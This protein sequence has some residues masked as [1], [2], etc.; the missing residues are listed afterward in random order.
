MP[1]S[2]RAR[3]TT[4]APR[5][6]PS[7]PGL[8]TRTRIWRCWVMGLPL[9]LALDQLDED[10]VGGA[11]RDEG[12]G[13]ARRRVVDAHTPGAQLFQRLGH[14]V[15]GERDEIEALALVLQVVR[16]RPALAEGRDQLDEGAADGEYRL[17]DAE[18]LVL[19]FALQRQAE[20]L[21]PGLGGGVQVADGDDD[22]VEVGDGH[23]LLAFG[24]GF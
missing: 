15:D 16:H 19:A 22:V 24:A 11:R 7:R 8:A 4:L 18:A 21:L 13:A 3:A 1:A 20:V 12:D 5:S 17:V 6:W 9:R 14:V 10:A 2:R 23:M